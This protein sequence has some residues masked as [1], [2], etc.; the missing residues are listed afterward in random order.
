MSTLLEIVTRAVELGLDEFEVT[1][2]TG[3]YMV[4]IGES[5][6]APEPITL[7]LLP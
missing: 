4:R 7:G 3:T 1:D 6:P 2:S 5:V